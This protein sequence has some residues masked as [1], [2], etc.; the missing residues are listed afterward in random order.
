MGSPTPSIIKRC[1]QESNQSRLDIQCDFNLVTVVLNVVWTV[2]ESFSKHDAAVKSCT[3]NTRKSRF[4]CECVCV[5]RLKDSI[6]G[7][8]GNGV[9][10][11][12]CDV[13]YIT[14]AETVVCSS[15]FTIVEVYCVTRGPGC[16]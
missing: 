11:S 7:R 13:D 1:N 3:S 10:C 8:F 12:C 5:Y 15:Y 2:C 16:C 6:R 4:R 9:T 14:L